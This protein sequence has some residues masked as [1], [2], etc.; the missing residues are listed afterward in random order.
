[1]RK[2]HHPWTPVAYKTSDVAAIQALVRGEA[3]PE[4]QQGALKWIIETAAATYDMVFMPAGD[5]DTSFALGRVFVGQ[6]IVK[7]TRLNL[8]TL[9]SEDD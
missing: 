8:S 6:Q 2:E 1:M 9:R 4:Q 7:A 5:R 3:T